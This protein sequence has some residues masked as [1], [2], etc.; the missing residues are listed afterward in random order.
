M[1]RRTVFI[2]FGAA[3]VLA[4]VTAIVVGQLAGERLVGPTP[5][6]PP[7]AEPT[8]DPTP[9]RAAPEDF[10]RVEDREAGFAVSYP[11]DWERLEVDD[12]HVRLLVT[13]NRADSILVRVVPLDAEIT[14]EDLPAVR[15]FTDELVEGEDIE[16][17]MDDPTQ[18]EVGGL[19]GIY[20]LYT[21]V[22][23]DTDEQ[24]VHAHYFLFDGATMFTV[25]LQA[26]PL[27]RF[28]PLA[29]TFDAVMATFEP[30]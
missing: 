13:P 5:E 29:P 27:E 3:V 28:D 26:L 2:L 7:E 12:P 8:P 10:T 15:T 30:L 14:E 25:V 24:G 21:F 6:E 1:Q 9:D 23:E 18:V 19:P 17:L 11:A 16:H 22:D 20:Y 4:A